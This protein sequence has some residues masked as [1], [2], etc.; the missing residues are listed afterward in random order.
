MLQRDGPDLLGT[1]T[2]GAVV[3]ASDR[4]DCDG[5]RPEASVSMIRSIDQVEV[6]RSGEGKAPTAR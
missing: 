4:C 3:P 2:L 5:H 1:T 6:N